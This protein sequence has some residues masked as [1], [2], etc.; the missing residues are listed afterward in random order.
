MD[1]TCT[2]MGARLLKRW[3]DEPLLN[4]DAI[5]ARLDAVEALVQ[6]NL[7]RDAIRQM[8]RP[9]ADLERLSALAATGTANA[10][11]LVAL[12]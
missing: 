4:P 9:F 11:D 8:V 7:H 2:P 5:Q 6:Q 10:R 12:R 3:L 1:S